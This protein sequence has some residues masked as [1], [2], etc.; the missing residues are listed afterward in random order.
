MKSG[1]QVIAAKSVNAKEDTTV[2]WLNAKTRKNAVTMLSAFQM[3]KAI[4]IASQQVQWMFG[5]KT[6]MYLQWNW[7]LVFSASH[8]GFDECEIER[9]RH[10]E[11]D[12]RTFDRLRYDYEGEHSYVLVLTRNLPTNLPAVYIESINGHSE[13]DDSDSDHHEDSSSSEEDHS[14]RVSYEEDEDEDDDDDK[15]SSDYSRKKHGSHHHGAQELKIRVYNH[16][17]E[18]KNRRR[19]VVSMK[20]MFFIL[21]HITSFSFDALLVNSISRLLDNILFFDHPQPFEKALRE[22][23]GS[24]SHFLYFC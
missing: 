2:E 4:T 21:E 18:F 9:D 20:L 6:F 7:F 15:D 11:T 19:L 13:H 10:R 1:T 3:K 22:I 8:A 17:V 5:F 12:Y 24:L 16:T 14:H 23:N